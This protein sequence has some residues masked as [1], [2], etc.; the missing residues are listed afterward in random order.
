MAAK[1]SV[2][3]INRPA[4]R[5]DDNN[6][7]V[8]GFLRNRDTWLRQVVDDKA[9][10]HPTVRVALHIAMRTD[11]RDTDRG[12]WPSIATIS[13]STG[14]SARGVIYALDELQGFVD[15]KQPGRKDGRVYLSASRKRNA[16]N[17]YW[18]NFW[19]E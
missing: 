11:G 7:D 12:A 13:K 14:V 10:S 8:S 2:R 15:R 5:D 4:N 16:G 1:K 3:P 18:L 19:W 9:L 6:G 17:T